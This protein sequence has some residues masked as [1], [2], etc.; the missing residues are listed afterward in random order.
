MSFCKDD[1][2]AHV[3]ATEAFMGVGLVCAYIPEPIWR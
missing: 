2:V 1:E 3:T